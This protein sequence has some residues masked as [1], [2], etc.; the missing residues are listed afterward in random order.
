MG[1]VYRAEDTRLGRP[2]ALKFLPAELA[3]DRSA[4]ERFEREARAVSALNHPH[5]CT[6]YDIGEHG[7]QPFLVLEFLEGQTLS[8]VIAGKAVP[9]D[10]LLD[11]GIQIADA[12]DAAH[13]KGIVHRDI[14]PAN[15]FV[16]A[17]GRAKILDF[18]L[19]KLTGPLTLGPSPAGRGGPEGRGEGE[20]P[21][22]S[23]DPE[24]LT[25]P[26]VAMGTIAYMS[27]EQARGEELDA[28]T[29]LFSLGAVL[30]EMAT[31]RAAFP[32]ATVA[33]VFDAVMNRPPVPARQ[34]NPE[35]PPQ[36]EP[37]LDQALE[38]DRAH[39]YKTASELLAELR[40]LR[41]ASEASQPVTTRRTLARAGRWRWLAAAAI[42]LLALLAALFTRRANERVRPKAL[43]GTVQA[44][45]VLPLTNFSGDPQQEYFVDG[46]TDELITRLAQLGAVRV[47][48][49][50]S[51][52]RYKGTQKSLPEIARDLHVDAV[53][54]GSVLRS[55]QRV[56]ITAQLIRASTD[57]HLWAETYDRDLQDVL[58]LQSE[59]AR[60]IAQQVTLKLSPQEQARLANAPRV[61]PAAYEAYL[62]GRFHMSEFDRSELETAI[63]LFER[64][65]AIDPQFALAHA[66]LAGACVSE[67]FSW[68]PRKEWEEKAYVEIEKALALDPNLPEA[69]LARGNLAWTLSNH[70]PHQRAAADLRRALLLN[71]N[72]V[73]AH[74]SLGSIYLHVGLV[75]KALDELNAG[76]AVDPHNTKALY[77]LPRMYI[78]QQ[79]YQRA[80]SEFESNPEFAG[81]ALWQKALV[82]AYLGRRA[83]ALQ[84]IEKLNR[85][86]PRQE[87]LASTY[88]ILLALGGDKAKALAKIR[89]AIDVGQGRSHFHHAEY[90]IA[91]AYALLGMKKQALEWLRKTAEDG[92]PCYPLFDKDPN[93]NNLRGDPEFTAFMQHSRTDWDRLRTTLE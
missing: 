60:S 28:R 76:L 6:L 37:V 19:A 86:H 10:Q 82:L 42:A 49:R 57:E 54:E 25:R 45:A 55:G 41:R 16:T 93:L 34:L 12:L 44:L 91:S 21:T 79:Q 62:R 85:E 29:D 68:D 80:L 89:L 35:L 24:Q 83:E 84:L 4:V 56:R 81:E 71:P 52:M 27:P 15:I 48:S 59:V 61:N 23:I 26:G 33:V 65:V 30:Y 7:G 50:T 43:A 88:A 53:V 75:D 70:F 17:Q 73:G 14:K 92:L 40:L 72:L 31:G 39:R 22:A 69:Y 18:G 38:K 67:F 11:L 32:G 1:V 51:V 90:N 9:T 74:F 64:A 3:R 5:I 78:Y 36:F 58:A 87:D 47:I 13:Q 20:T 2:V 66:D 46:M 8:H 63:G 77:R